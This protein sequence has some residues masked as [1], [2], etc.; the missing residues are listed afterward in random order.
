MIQGETGDVAETLESVDGVYV[1]V[2][3]DVAEEL[4]VDSGGD[5]T[6]DVRAAG[7]LVGLDASIGLEGDEGVDGV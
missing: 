6:A 2:A 3:V 5:G 7:L 4:R 1:A